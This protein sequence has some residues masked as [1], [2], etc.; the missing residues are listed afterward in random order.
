MAA[1]VSRFLGNE[2]AEPVKLAWEDP[3]LLWVVREPFVSRHSSARF[4]AGFL[5]PGESLRLESLMP[6]NGVVFGDGM[7]KDFL[8][9][10]SGAV[11]EIRAAEVRARLV[12][13]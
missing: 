4:T 2:S 13:N 7:E 11:A 8:A 12:V 6:Q 5:E 9:F 10:N 1:S 3:R